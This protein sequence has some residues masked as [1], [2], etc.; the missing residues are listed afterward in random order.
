MIPTRIQKLRAK[1][2]RTAQDW[3]PPISS[4]LADQKFPLTETLEVEVILDRF[5]TELPRLAGVEVS[6]VGESLF[7]LSPADR[8]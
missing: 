6:A 3:M 5:A 7:Q 8:G 2:L 1:R 4:R